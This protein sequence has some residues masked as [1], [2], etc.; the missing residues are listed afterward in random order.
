MFSRLEDGDQSVSLE[1]D[2]SEW[3]QQTIAASIVSLRFCAHLAAITV[4][5]PARMVSLTSDS[6]FREHQ[7][8]E[9]W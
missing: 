4:V 6:A 2:I 9:L 8:S 3:S 7:A 5:R 1:L